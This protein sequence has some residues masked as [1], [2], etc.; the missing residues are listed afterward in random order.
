[1]EMMGNYTNVKIHVCMFTHVGISKWCVF[2]GLLSLVSPALPDS[3]NLSKFSMLLMFFMKI[4][5]NL[6][7][8]DIGDW[9][10]VHKSTVCRNFHHVL[11]VMTLKTAFLVKWPDL[12]TD[13]AYSFSTKGK[14]QLKKVDIDWSRELSFVRIHVEH[15]IRM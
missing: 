14:K 3:P 8:E 6:F 4:R 2:E 13:D 5:L 11:D 15:V 7:N 1:M 10:G 9:F 12:P